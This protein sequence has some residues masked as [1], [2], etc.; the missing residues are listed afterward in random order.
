MRE[1][2]EVWNPTKATRV[3]LGYADKILAEYKKQ[4]Y[5]LSLRQ[6]YYQMVAADLIPNS[7]RSY[8]RLGSIIDQ[9][10]KAG[11]I[12]WDMIV[13]RNRSVQAVSHWDHPGEILV[14]AASSF[15]MDKWRGQQ[16]RIIVAVEK[17]ALSGVLE[18]VCRREDVFF[19]AN[20]GYASSSHLYRIGKMVQRWSKY[21]D[22]EAVIIY[23]GDHDPSGLDMDR[24]IE[25]RV[26]TF[27]Y[28]TLQHISRAALTWEQI[29]QYNPP[30]NPAK[31]TDSRSDGYIA[32]HGRQSWELD[33]LKPEVLDALVT[34]KILEYR[35]NDLWEAALKLE[36]E[37]RQEL[38]ELAKKYDNRHEEDYDVD[39]DAE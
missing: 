21:A 7:V 9:A 30:P 4:G 35:D 10:R 6:L 15:R 26:W 32:E 19:T 2:F 13:D 5:D 3:T 8:K 16:Y 27:S 17:D 23:L 31:E 11:L 36:K 37:Y 39:P 34:E 24:D 22:Q 25:D 20:K 18:P 28:G 33:A 14:S 12:D 1:Q 29:E 38:T